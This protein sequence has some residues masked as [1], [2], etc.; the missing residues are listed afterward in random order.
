MP[1]LVLLCHLETHIISC[2]RILGNREFAQ[3]YAYDCVYMKT[4]T[5]STHRPI[6][7]FLPC[8]IRF[9]WERV[10][11]FIG[12]IASSAMPVLRGN[13][14][15]TKTVS[16]HRSTADCLF[17]CTSCHVKWLHP[18]NLLVLLFYERTAV[19]AKDYRGF[20]PVHS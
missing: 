19:F 8:A 17:S 6:R 14:S 9:N 3:S 5:T 1:L 13:G 2:D 4:D 11:R 7:E 20:Q 16:Q 10:K 18:T 12:R 15:T